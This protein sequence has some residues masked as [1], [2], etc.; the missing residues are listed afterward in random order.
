MIISRTPFRVSFAGGGSDI[1]A[2]YRINGGS[3]L[4]ATINKYI[5]LSLHRY[6]YKNM[7]FLKYS[8]NEIV[9][10][11]SEIKHRIIKEVFT[12]YSINGVDFNSSADI[13]SGTGLGSSS[14]FTVGLI[15]L[16]NAYSSKYSTKEEIAKLAC[17]IEIDRLKEPIGKQDQYACAF[18]GLNFI[19]FNEDE[20][21]TLEK[22][23][24][25][26]EKMIELN[27]NLMMFFT[28]KIR[29]ASKI[30]Q[31]QKNN[32][33]INKLKS[34]NLKK[35]VDLSCCLKSDLQNGNIETFGDILHQGWK[36]KKELADEISD[37]IINFYYEKALK[38]GARGGKLLGA[39]GGGFLLFYCPREKQTQLISALKELFFVPFKF[40]EMG[41]TIIYSD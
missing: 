12:E 37:E 36:Y 13:P 38:N 17:Q 8:Q 23:F 14:A 4:S 10:K 6:F 19:R 15:N 26:K 39:G 18:G 16:C 9:E 2:Y 21:V 29:S 30:L 7:Y 11:T 31:Q 40:D 22:I 34:N 41:T 27:D 20:S 35:I 32:L 1:P 5:Y 24:L 28:G 3:V 33:N 25:P